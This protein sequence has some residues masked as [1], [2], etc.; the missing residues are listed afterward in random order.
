MVPSSAAL[1]TL[2]QLPPGKPGRGELIAFGDPLFSVEQ[3]AEAEQAGTPIKVAD[4]GDGHDTRR[5]AQAPL[6][7]EA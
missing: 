3:A 2:R 6:K 4:A 7:P 5:A 1:R